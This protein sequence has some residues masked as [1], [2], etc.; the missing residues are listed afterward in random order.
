MKK[1]RRKYIQTAGGIVLIAAMFVLS[2]FIG[3]MRLFVFS[4]N[5]IHDTFFQMRDAFSAH[6]KTM[7]SVVI[8]GIDKTTLAAYP[9]P[10]IF[11]D[12]EFS[13]AIE[14][15]SRAKPGAIGFDI[16]HLSSVDSRRH[17]FSKMKLGSLLMAK[18]ECVLPYA[19]DSG[20]V[21][22]PVFLAKQYREKFG[23]AGEM[24][25]DVKLK[26][27]A[28]A[29]RARGT[30]FGYANL[31]DDEDGIVRRVELY[32]PS[33]KSRIES[34]SLK[35]FLK[36]AR[37]TG[38]NITRTE[39]GTSV[40]GFLLPKTLTINY[41]GAP[42]SIPMIPMIDVIRNAKSESY[43][44][45][46]FEGKI[47]VFGSYDPAL[48]DVH[49]TPFIS[50]NL[51]V[52]RG[53]YGAEIVANAVDTLVKK[54]LV[55]NSP[56]YLTLLFCLIFSVLGMMLSRLRTT[57][58]L[59]GF[60]AA[61]LLYVLFAY[62]LFAGFSFLTSMLPAVAL[63]LSFFTGYLFSHYLVGRDKFLLQSVLGSYLD[64]RIVERVV[65][66]RGSEILKGEHRYITVMFAD[67]RNFT[68]LSESKKNP[69]D[70]VE[71]LNIY[72]PAMSAVIR[73]HEGCV[74]KFIGDGIMAFWNAPNDVE[75]H[76][77]KAVR[78]AIEMQKTLVQVNSD[79]RA[80]GLIRSDIAVGIGM[81]TGSAVVGN[82][83]SEIKNDYT[84][85]GD[86]VNTASRLEGKTKDLGYPI[87]ISEAV[88]SLLSKDDVGVRSAGT[89]AVKGKKKKI[90]VFGIV[91]QQY[92]S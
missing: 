4:E 6:D 30:S 49:N 8:V 67:I 11:W 60:I 72:L 27:L 90:R 32:D 77:Q 34:F 87:V 42:G 45:K 23:I 2:L 36:Y 79:A 84:A 40:N 70:V 39:R 19:I 24:T 57:R 75:N 46:N 59:A 12:N 89:I 38:A 71:I 54:K 76:A 64:P 53:M 91:L 37:F 88:K 25:L 48:G 10:L 13:S 73:K 52:T 26:L 41:T 18:P 29:E 7:S 55:S 17:D 63:F 82:V 65:A 68:S 74:D 61:G 85:I 5:K 22:I 92:T 47:V 43:L 51:G 80:R 33:R 56:S 78:C 58:G 16:L 20:D 28:I 62:I 1:I 15:L 86:T 69:E 3:N 21:A 31:S 81:H 50:S 9:E 66:E 83:G 35:I 44:R 14:A